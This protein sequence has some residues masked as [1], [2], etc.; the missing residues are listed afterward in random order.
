M[1]LEAN[2]EGFLERAKNLADAIKEHIQADEFI[3]VISHHDADGL[4]SASIVGAALARAK[5]RFTIRIVEEL[6]EENVDELSKQKPDTII[7]ADIGSGYMELLAKRLDVKSSFILDH[8]PPN[9]EVPKNI[10][11]LNPHEFGIDG[12]K[13]VSAA[14]VCYLVARELSTENKDL[15]AVAVVGALGDM[16][17]KNDKRA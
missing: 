12:A 9:A 2:Q 5:A 10:F 15:S 6:R 17:D 16:Q 8:H 7:F 14:G 3:Q 11:Q 13:L 4:S 1:P